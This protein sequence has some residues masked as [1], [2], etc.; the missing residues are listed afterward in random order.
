LK[1]N[2]LVKIFCLKEKSFYLRLVQSVR[3][4]IILVGFMGSGKTTFGKKIASGLSLPFFDVDAFIEMQ[5]GMTIAEIFSRFGEE[6]FRDLERTCILNLQ[7]NHQGVIAVGGGLPCYKDN[8][9][10]LLRLGLVFYLERSPKELFQRLIQAKKRRPLLVELS[11]NELLNY[12]EQKLKER[13]PYYKQADHK[14]C[15][16]EQN[17]ES[18]IRLLKD[19]QLG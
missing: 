12:I 19:H 14:L 13:M 10:I 16:T 7:E 9:S 4:N 5:T 17:V 6:H 1:I 11:E 18:V 15:R 3:K 8:M 2:I